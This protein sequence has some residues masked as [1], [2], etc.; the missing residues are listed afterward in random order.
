MDQEK[1]VLNQQQ[2][3]A[4]EFGNGPL[5]IIAGAGTGKTTVVTER[6][7][8]LITSKLAKPQEILALT[9][10]EKAALE[11]EERVDQ[12][13]PLGFFQMWISTF[14]SFCDR[15][16]RDEALHIG[17]D[18]HYTLMTEAETLLFLK[19]NLFNFELDYFRPAGNPFKFLNGLLTHFS[20]LK[21]EDVMSKNYL[22]YA[23]KLQ[24]MSQIEK[25]EIRKTLELAKAYQKYEELK[26]KEGMMDFADL[27]SNTLRLFRQRKNI[28]AQYHKKFKY[29]LVDEYQDTNISQNEMVKLLVGKKPNLTVVADDDQ[30]IYKWRG[31]AI[32]N[33][34]QFKK[35]YPR[36]KVITLTQNYRST[37]E[38]LNRAYDLIQHNNPDRLEI[39]EKIDKKLIAVRK[40]KGKAIKF[41]LADRVENEADFVAGEIQ[42]LTNYD[43]KDIAILVRANNHADAFVRSFLRTGIP[44][45]FLGPGKL[46]RQEE[47][48]DLI[49]YLK[50]LYNFEDNVAFF[51]ILSMPIFDISSRDVTAIRNLAKRSN[52]SL[53]E[54]A[55]KTDHLSI[56]DK[57]REKV[58]KIIQMIHRHLAMI[59][60]QTAGQILYYFLKDTG[61][62]QKM[63]Q[64]KTQ[65]QEQEVGNVAKFF[66]KLKN[67][68]ANH[69]DASVETVVDWLNLKMEMGES[70]L[71]ADLDWTQENKVNILTVHSSKGLEF[72]IV[73]L[74][75]L[76]NERFPTR[77]RAEQIPLPEDLVKEVLPEGDSHEQEERRLFYVGMTRARDQLYLTAAKFYGEAKRRKKISAF[78]PE[79]LGKQFSQQITEQKESSQLSIFDFKPQGQDQESVSASSG[80]YPVTYLSYS[81]LDTFNRCPLQYKYKYIIGIPTPLSAA[82]SFGICLHNTLKDLYQQHQQ[83]KALNL[84][85]I[86]KN[87]DN[88]WIKEGYSSKNHEK[89]MYQR[90]QE[91]L[92]TYWQKTYQKKDN[93][94]ALEQT[95][96][97]KIT[98]TLKIG[99]RIDR[100]DRLPNGTLEVIDYKTG[101]VPEQKQVDMSLQMTFYAMAASNPNIFNTDPENIILSFYFLQ[102]QEKI[103]TRRS[104]EDLKQTQKEIIDQAKKMEKSDFLPQPSLLCDFCDFKLLCPAWQ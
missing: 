50:I 83:K 13:M 90:A 34:L 72:P 95:F 1:K 79:A 58:K 102:N 84:K 77:R 47:I 64:V 73:F 19:K 93:P 27:I 103:S 69:E 80:Y 71:A 87:L 31:A 59:P 82:A 48:K 63:T 70:P 81:Q 88:A 57:S 22:V 8:H 3:E 30:S 21:D 96:A 99:G 100:V 5:L 16:L 42:K 55:E 98:P 66:D 18:S 35:T 52:F 33:V 97:L 23:K 78:V 38:I 36:A 91:M 86:L 43:F 26:V 49:S 9:F 14:H 4:I 94:I 56:A 76:V 29:I 74:V 60:K 37:Q 65:K 44:F 7:K 39:R 53:F 46:L 17:L 67:Y 2:L 32:S 92:K 11:M 10:T 89:K 68:E 25:D 104:Q 75:N 41:V 24:T 101:K 20:R 54:A 6:I 45:Q 28:L 61:L 12:I 85:K 15:I 62:L 51:R 40:I